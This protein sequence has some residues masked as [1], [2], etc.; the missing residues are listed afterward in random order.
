LKKHFSSLGGVK[1]CVLG[2]AFRPDTNDMRESPAIPII[3]SLLGEGAVVHAYD[4]VAE[5]EA[6]R[7]FSA[8]ELEFSGS[9]SD[10]LGRAE[11]VVLVTRWDEFRKVPELL[12]GLTPQPVFIDGRRLLDKTSIVRYEGIG[13]E[14]T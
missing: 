14:T 7:I 4:P 8:S 5:E 13:L 6:R 3:R 10:A 11:A 12:K 2:L 1:V 9:L